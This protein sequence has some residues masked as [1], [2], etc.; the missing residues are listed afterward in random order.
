[1]II[2]TCGINSIENITELTQLP[3]D[4][5]GLIFHPNSPR[6]AAHNQALIEHLRN[7]PTHAKR[8]GVFVNASKAF[9]QEQI[10]TFQLDGVQF[11]GNESQNFMNNFTNEMITI[12]VF[13]IH[14]DFD[15]TICN[16]YKADYF[17]FDTSS[18]NHGGSG[19]KFN[20]DLLT[21]Y[22]GKIPFILS[23]GVGPTDSY[24][25]LQINHPYMAGV[26]INSQFELEPGLKNPYLI[27]QFIQQVS[28][29]TL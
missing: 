20:W 17:L 27:H 19:Q 11:H 12:K 5:I 7:C 26:D 21:H 22:A 9:I 25:I 29:P 24:K 1:M 2:K 8:I 13:K 28:C 6:F 23:G 3:L 10:E 4:M 16:H 15:F 18:R 14:S